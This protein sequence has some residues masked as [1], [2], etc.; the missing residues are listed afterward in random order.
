[1]EKCSPT[2]TDP[3]S[4]L[5]I[6]YAWLDPF[7]LGPIIQKAGLAWGQHPG[8]LVAVWH[9]WSQDVWRWQGAAWQ[10]WITPKSEDPFPAKEDDQRFTQA[11]WQESPFWDSIKEWYLFNTRWLQDTL[12][13]TP[14]LDDRERNLAAFWLRQW[15]NAIAPTNFLP[16]NP[17]AQH[18]ALETRGES[19]LAGARNFLR[20][21]A[22]GS[23]AMTDRDAFQVGKN[24]ATTPGSVVYRGKLLEVI[25]YQAESDK[26]HAVPMVIVSPW[27]NKYYVLDLDDKKSLIR[28]LV[29]QGFSVF[30]TS[31]K[32]PGPEDSELA[33]DD[34]VTEGIDR[35]A[36]VAREISGNATVHVTGYCI[37][38]TL[39]SLWL[40]W[41]ARRK[42]ADKV[43]SATLLTTLTDFER[44]GDIEV[45]ID[46]DGLAFIDRKMAQQGFLDGKDM[47]AS[48]RMLRSNSLIWNYWV[49]NYL[50]GETPKAFDILYWNMDTT[51]M[52]R[53]MH[54]FYLREFYQHN[55]LKD[56]DALTIAG[57]KI[58]LGRITTPLFMVSTEEDHIAPWKQTWKLIPRVASELTFTLSSSGHILGIVNPPSPTSRR[59]Y[60]QGRPGRTENPEEWFA[61]Q[62]CQPGSWWPSWVEWLAPRSGG[63][64]DFKMSSRKHPRLCDAPGTYVLE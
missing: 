10:G 30:V 58:D 47:A 1:M 17:V 41:L 34:Y 11:I 33:F 53:K 61:E 39:T 64:V 35:I 38:G 40:A 23:I 9:N 29:K 3:R 22:E 15:L 25:H 12:Y 16:L 63:M 56:P 14:D 55:K 26:V 21:V 48:F 59:Q 54:S 49:G 36:E 2:V 32:N 24:L 31:W 50:M 51:R 60:W 7:M 57:Q 45:F 46:E 44:P 8:E 20:D 4:M 18:R 43:A 27:I 5:P 13:I 42:E 37:G 6:W 19:L 52:P 28:F 62:A